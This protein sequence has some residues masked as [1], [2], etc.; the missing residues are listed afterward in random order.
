MTEPQTNTLDPHPCDDFV[1]LHMHTEYSLLDGTIRTKQAVQRAKSLGQKALAIT[2]S[3]NLFGA[4][5]F[6]TNC[7][8]AGIKA[9]I[10]CEIYFEGLAET[11]TIAKSRKDSA[12][13]IG[14]F[15]LVTL[16][17]NQEGYKELCK[18]VSKAYTE[19]LHGIP[20]ASLDH[21]KSHLKEHI[22]LSG[23][24]KSELAYLVSLLRKLQCPDDS[25]EKSLEFN[26]EVISDG[27]QLEILK[28]I[29]AH[30][31]LVTGLVGHG[32]YYI[33]LIDNQIDGQL[34]LNKDLL[35][36]AR[37]F[38]LPIVCTADAHY[39]DESFAPSYAVFVAIK[40]GVTFKELRGRNK[41]ARFHLQSIDEIKASFSHIPEAIANT[42]KIAD[43]CNV[44]FE[45]GKYYLPK[46][47]VPEGQ[48]ESDYLG[49]IATSMLEERLVHLAKLYGPSFDEDK[50]N[51]Y[52]ERLKYEISVIQKMGFPG[53][54]LIVQDFINWAKS[55]N[56]PVGPG[57]GSGAGSLVA[58]SLRITDIDPLRFNLLFE[59]FL[60][61]ER[62][63][64]PDFDVDFCQDRRQEVID[65]VS[66]KYGSEH[67]AQ[68][69]TFGKMKTKL[70]V[71]D[72]GRVM[73]LSYGRVDK[74][75]KLIPNK[76]QNEK[77]EDVDPTIALAMKAEPKL[78]EESDRDS[79]VAEILRIT[80]DLEGL[81]RQTG[82]HAAGVVMSD[83][84]MTDYVPVF[85][86]E[87]GG[88][89]TQFEMKN[90][91]KVGLVKFDFLGLKTL[92]VIQKAIE[93]IHKQ[94]DPLFDIASIEL[95]DKKVYDQ[96]SQGHT[97]GIFQLEGDGMIQLVK[98]LKPSCFEDIIA[99]VA[100]FRPGPLG[101]GM[102]D[103]F[104][105]RKHG[106]QEIKY[107]LPD[108][109]TILKETYGVILYQEQV[110]K[111]AVI[112][113]NYTPGEADLLRRAMGKKDKEVMAKQKLRFLEGAA[114]NQHDLE[115]AGEIFDL[116]AKFA[117]YGFNKSHSAAYGLVSYQT[118]Y[119]KTHFRDLFMAA[120]MTC[121]SDD[122]DKVIRYAQ[123]CKRMGIKLIRP[124]VN[125]SKLE[126]EV[127][128]P[129]T[130]TWG[131]GAIKGIGAPSIQPLVQERTKNGPFETLVDMAYRVD[132]HK[133]VGKKTLELMIR[134]GALDCFGMTR[135]HMLSIIGDVVK[136]SEEYHQNKKK[137]QRSL[138]D[139]AEQGP[140]Q[141]VDDAPGSDP[142][143]YGDPSVTLPVTLESLSDEKKLIGI[144]MSGHPLDF[145]QHDL[146]RFGKCTLGETQMMAGKGPFTI[147]A[148]IHETNERLSKDN[149]R[150]CYVA[151]ED[152]T[153][154][155]EALMGE[156]D[157]PKAFPVPGTP[158]LVTAIVRKLPD[159]AVS[160]R[161]KITRV[162]ALEEVRARA[163]KG[164][165][166]SVDT[167]QKIPA[168]AGATISP[169]P[170]PEERINA[171]CQTLKDLRG[172][173]ELYFEVIYPESTVK[174][175]ADFQ[176]ELTDKLLRSLR[177]LSLSG[178]YL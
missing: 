113:A 169:I 4:V 56:I 112:L 9:I 76:V 114:Q 10:G 71:R 125:L 102:V 119:L 22:V 149:K 35:S 92:T 85:T 110:Q 89:I 106:R 122:T 15:H 135:E 5:E 20:I 57:R 163:I 43:A 115:K 166:I 74:I 111:T 141:S 170:P 34:Q 61:P 58:Y 120:I 136:F 82:M 78:R 104:V 50:K 17:R 77:G 129:D 145:Y 98:K 117:E 16:C 6:Y 29:N 55:Q 84:P 65:Y 159:G 1:H 168:R 160:S 24:A 177:N 178:R 88:L 67:V 165:V 176:V 123:D 95:E 38:G 161:L 118:A 152:R 130:I 138:F 171:V 96:I 133:E 156:Q 79:V 134:I 28:D 164:L 51:T 68:I 69:C 105:E 97:I 124:H 3:G 46:F 94:K 8:A 63:S 62:I 155:L 37:H 25:S 73:E 127:T 41:K 60:N 19:G 151:L 27:E 64:M 162:I 126:F 132:L 2:D 42:V 121:D 174:I 33:E 32:H 158:V 101:S 139:T 147:V 30:I 12:A 36:L 45:F 103:D 86:T 150:L 21:I 108:L 75:A 154:S 137:G 14:A 31:S 80:A 7:K 87:E 70:A 49:A 99:L 81:N 47:K 54:F 140:V 173:T 157:I 59:R 100:L 26:A 48:T 53:Y 23:D 109:E 143:W 91:E 116:M 83:G 175:K 146:K 11:R 148:M 128:S 131:L 66:R 142:L 39:L 167:R 40:A 93:L 172:P 72:V 44:S 144:Y 52:R 18:L 107:P 90:A 153:A 13:H